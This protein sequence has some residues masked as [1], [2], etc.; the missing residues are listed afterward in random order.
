MVEYGTDA[1]ERVGRKILLAVFYAGDGTLRGLELFGE[2]GLRK[3]ALL[4]EVADKDA[5]MFKAI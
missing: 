1:R 2:L 5:D 4:A 3:P